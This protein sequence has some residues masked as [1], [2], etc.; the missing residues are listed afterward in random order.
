MVYK[1]IWGQVA[2]PLRICF[3]HYSDGRA[4]IVQVC[5]EVDQPSGFTYLLEADRATGSTNL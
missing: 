3:G 1:L 2:D 5:A 4:S